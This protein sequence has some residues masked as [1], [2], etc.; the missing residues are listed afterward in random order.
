MFGQRF[1]KTKSS[2]E[3]LE[4]LEKEYQKKFQ[5]TRINLK[6]LKEKKSEKE[7]EKYELDEKIDLLQSELTNIR[8]KAKKCDT[9]ITS[10]TVELSNT[11]K[12]YENLVKESSEK[13]NAIK[14]N[15]DKLRIDKEQLKTV[16]NFSF[17]D[18]FSDINNV[19][20]CICCTEM[21]GLNGAAIYQCTEGH[22]ICPDCHE[23]L[24]S[25]PKCQKPYEKPG[26]RCRFAE[27]CALYN[28][29]KLNLKNF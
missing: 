29:V 1:E 9:E 20:E 3:K 15:I 27:S 14:E 21:M 10:I 11:E 17:N 13:V 23:T 16:D 6:K 19:L 26:I 7:K 8:I 28:A 18:L 5:E 2:L 25:C 22:L 24:T 12:S 4:N